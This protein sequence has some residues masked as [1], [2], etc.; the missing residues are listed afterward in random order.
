M[1]VAVLFMVRRFLT[2]PRRFCTVDLFSAITLEMRKCK[3]EKAKRSVTGQGNTRTIKSEEQLSKMNGS[4]S[5]A[6]K[7]AIELRYANSPHD[8]AM[9]VSPCPRDI[10]AYA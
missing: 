4:R 8:V 2:W 7:L 5:K 3:I 10:S 9:M 6:S 1:V